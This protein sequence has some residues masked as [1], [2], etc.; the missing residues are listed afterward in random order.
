MPNTKNFEWIDLVKPSRQEMEK[1]ARKYLLHPLAVENALQY[2][3]RPK[4][5][6]YP[7]HLF[8]ALHEPEMKNTHV[9]EIELDVLLGKNFVITVS[10]KKLKLVSEL[11]ARYEKEKALYSKGPDHLVYLLLDEVVDNYFPILDSVDSK[12]SALEQNVF[13]RP[14][15]TILND[16]FKMKKAMLQLRKIANPQREILNFLTRH[17]SK[18]ISEKH[19]LYFRDVYDHLTRV[20]DT[21]DIYRDVI[22]NATEAYLSVI[23]NKLNEIMKLLTI[24]AT[25]MLPLTLIS[26]IY[27]MNFLFIPEIH[28]E[29]GRQYGY[30]FALSL[31]LIIALIM[32]A[33]FKKKKWL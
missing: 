19:I 33:W 24:I 22:S 9:S 23:S 10:D 26:G 32:V 4:V 27:G 18:Y 21:I 20:N 7:N 12:I 31:M 30:Y 6:E 8:I 5:D 17:E 11:K 28:S 13:S 3:Q 15:K 16:L 14:S 2:V 29:F 1:I 25:I